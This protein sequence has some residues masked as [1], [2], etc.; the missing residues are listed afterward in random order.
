MR[1]GLFFLLFLASVKC[2]AQQKPI[3]GIVFDKD[4]KERIASVSVHD[5][6]NG[7]AVYDNLKGVFS[8][9]ANEG[10]QLVFTRQDYHSDTVKVKNQETVVV[11][12]SRIAIQLKLVTVRDSALTPEKRLEA[13]K[14]DYTKI[15][16]SLAYDD[17]LSVA[18]G[19][20]AGLSI[21]AL[22]NSISRS[23]RNATR[24]RQFIQQDYEQ[25]VIDY[26]FNRNF[27]SRITGLKDE[28]L[29]SFMIRYRPGFFTT[30][31]MTDYEFIT[32]IRANARRFLRSQRTYTIPPL[33]SKPN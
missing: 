28:K 20:G 15:Y 33:E 8:I 2:F 17:A 22:W 25:N 3:E 6:T 11:Y 30:Q 23:G 5:I 26:R 31:T 29:S 10:D 1:F 21:D 16:G 24:L 14:Q 12:M 27:V 18:P 9:K 32:M 13:T 4:S 19:G 7:I